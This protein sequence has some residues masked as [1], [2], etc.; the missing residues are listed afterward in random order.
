MSIGL[1]LSVRILSPTTRSD[2]GSD[3]P[4]MFGTIGA[5][6]RCRAGFKCSS[7]DAR[8]HSSSVSFPWSTNA[9]GRVSAA[10]LVL[11]LGNVKPFT[12]IVE[13]NS[14]LMAALVPLYLS[15][16]SARVGPRPQQTAAQD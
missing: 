11:L 13:N 7:P 5:T 16:F 15:Q 8:S 3:D 9:L 2:L 1:D 10:A 6:V 4:I 14:L 12:M